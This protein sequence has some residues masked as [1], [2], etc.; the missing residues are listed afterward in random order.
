MVLVIKKLIG[1]APITHPVH[2]D[3]RFPEERHP[4]TCLGDYYDR[5]I[6]DEEMGKREWG[7]R[8]EKSRGVHI[9]WKKLELK[10]GW[11]RRTGRFEEAMGRFWP[12]LSPRTHV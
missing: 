7:D 8:R 4:N 2:T 5:F 3:L 10:S 11:Q 12:R 9:L 1:K 6:F